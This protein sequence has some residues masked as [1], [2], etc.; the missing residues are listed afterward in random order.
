MKK[1][2]LGLVLII[3]IATIYYYQCQVQ[4]QKE[5]FI[6]AINRMYRPHVRNARVYLNNSLTTTSNYMTSLIRKTGLL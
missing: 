6:P 1:I 5:P 2:E 3:I 4:Q